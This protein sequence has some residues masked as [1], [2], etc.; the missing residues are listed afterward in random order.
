MEGIQTDF[1]IDKAV[2]LLNENSSRTLADLACGCTLS[3]SRLS[4]LFKDKTGLTVGK[5]R[6]NCRFE[7]AMKMLA[8]SLVSCEPLS[9]TREYHPV[10]IESMQSESTTQ[11]L[12]LTK[13]RKCQVHWVDEGE[14]PVETA[15][16]FP[17]MLLDASAHNFVAP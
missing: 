13:S 16:S 10:T 3:I 11:Q 7:A 1:R 14:R 15:S 2:R 8:T 9:V 5:F 17:Y 4:H 12:L 6:R